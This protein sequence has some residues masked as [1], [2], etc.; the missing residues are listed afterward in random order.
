[1][2][3]K[4]K[5]NYLDYTCLVQNQAYQSLN[6]IRNPRRRQVFRFRE[7]M[8][9]QVERKAEDISNSRQEQNRNRTKRKREREERED[10]N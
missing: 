2:E 7:E 4:D 9:D 6:T 10:Q 8:K 5:Q 3:A 1:M